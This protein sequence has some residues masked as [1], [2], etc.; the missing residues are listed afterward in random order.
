M[1]VKH[2]EIEEELT[3]K[4]N[5]PNFLVKNTYSGRFVRLGI[6]ETKYLLQALNANE[7]A[8]A[9]QMEEVEELPDNLKRQLDEK[10]EEWEFLYENTD[11]GKQKDKFIDL[12]KIKLISFN[13]EKLIHAVYP[14]YSKFFSRWGLFSLIAILIAD[15]SIIIYFLLS[16]SEKVQE[17]ISLVFSI[18]DIIITVMLFLLSTVAHELGHAVVCKKYGGKVKSMG[19]LLFYFFPCFY[20]DVSDIYGIQNKKYRARV[21]L[22][23]IFSNLFL[24][25]FTLLVAF[26]L[27]LYNIVPLSLY[28]FSISCLWV[29]FYNLIPFVKLDGYWLLS[30]VLE[31]TNLMDKGFI[32]AYT[33]LFDRKNIPNMNMV[34]VKRRW[35]ALYGVISFI[36]KPLFWGYNLF[37]LSDY[38]DMAVGLIVII[39]GILLI[40]LDFIKYARRYH[41]ILKHDYKRLLHMMS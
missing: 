22:A 40:L 39:L 41:R 21:A 25:L 18:K 4:S 9:L 38:F 6:R 26:I 19:L 2:L 8:I 13:V 10:F 14:F 7:E 15:V 29:S 31:V 3:G 30:A 5:L 1:E 33:T 23:G 35:I 27:L 32:A 28:Y 12:S 24:G 37:I 20:C 16:A 36:F 11:K 34:S 17:N